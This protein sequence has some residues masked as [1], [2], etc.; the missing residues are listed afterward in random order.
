MLQ[1]TVF[2]ELGRTVMSELGGTVLL[3]LGGTVMSELGGLAVRD[4]WAGLRLGAC[5]TAEIALS[6]NSL[7]PGEIPLCRH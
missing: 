2:L 3:E 4:E 7:A 6:A 5:R 1:L